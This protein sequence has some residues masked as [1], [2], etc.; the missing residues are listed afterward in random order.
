MF[1]VGDAPPHDDYQEIQSTGTSAKKARQLG[2]IIYTIQCGNMQETMTPWRNIAQYGGGEYFAI[3]QDGGV[4]NIATPYDAGLA[5]LGEKIGNTY[6]AYGRADMRHAKQKKQGAVESS[7]AAAAPVAARANRAVN[8]ALNTN[9]YDEADLVQKVAS[10]STTLDK[11]AESDLPDAL[12]TLKPAERQAKLQQTM[13]ERKAL[14]ARIIDVSKQRDAY[15]TRHRAANPS[16]FDASVAQALARQ[17][18]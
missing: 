13:A 5:R 3:E 17:I 15:L 2:I 6:L 8:K 14:Q 18:K 10:G 9:A 12:A 4:T 7:S 16:G 11:L 1:L